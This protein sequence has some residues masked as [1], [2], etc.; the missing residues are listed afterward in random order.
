MLKLIVFDRYD[1]AREAMSRL[2]TDLG[3]IAEYDRGPMRLR[4]KSG[5][6]IRA[7]VIATDSDV[8]RLNGLPVNEVQLRA[9]ISKYATDVLAA[10]CRPDVAG[11]RESN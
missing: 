4:F 11:T 7:V 2:A 8:R 3:G 1:K 10:I 9:P 6:Q 5:D